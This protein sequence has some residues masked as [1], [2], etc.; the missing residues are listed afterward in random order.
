[1]GDNQYYRLKA[2]AQKLD[3]SESTIYRLM[4]EEGFPKP[5]RLGERIKVWCWAEVQEWIAKQN[6]PTT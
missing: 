1:M 4:A 3:V 6:L 2:L 5:M